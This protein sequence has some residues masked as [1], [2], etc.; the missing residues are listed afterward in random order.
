MA[1][2]SFDAHTHVP[3]TL[4]NNRELLTRLEDSLGGTTTPRTI[5][6]ATRVAIY[7]KGLARALKRAR[8][9]SDRPLLF[10]QEPE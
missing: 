4:A 7:F 6:H 3:I 9:T 8:D 5:K 10:N 1:R 2:T